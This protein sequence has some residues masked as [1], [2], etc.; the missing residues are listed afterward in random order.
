MQKDKFLDQLRLLEGDQITA[1]LRKLLCL[2]STAS[3]RIVA[4]FEDVTEKNRTRTVY[5]TDADPDTGWDEFVSS[6]DPRMRSYYQG[7]TFLEMQTADG[8]SVAVRESGEQI[9]DQVGSEDVIPLPQE[10][11]AVIDATNVA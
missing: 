10:D 4:V 8:T 11:I 5:S 2:G 1:G 7:A 6:D 3:G 9:P